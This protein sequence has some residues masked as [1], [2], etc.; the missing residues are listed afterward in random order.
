MVNL[1]SEKGVIS[2]FRNHV[3][4]ASRFLE[5]RAGTTGT[6]KEGRKV[7]TEG[8]GEKGAR[9]ITRRVAALLSLLRLLL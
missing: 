4:L 8:G 1:P 9:S 5:W 7:L 6:R 3:N 2:F